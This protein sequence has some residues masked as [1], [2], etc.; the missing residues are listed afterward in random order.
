MSHSLTSLIEQ[1][2][3]A[4]HFDPTHVMSDEEIQHIIHLTTL[5]PTSFNFQNWKFIAVR[6]AEAKA[7]LSAVAFGQPKVT[8]AAVTFI[9]I[10]TLQPQ[11]HMAD[12]MKLSVDAGVIPQAQVD[13]WL[14]MAAHFYGDNAQMQ[15]DEAI[16]S[17][18]LAAMTL[19]LVAQ[20]KGLVSGPMIGFD[21]AGVTREFA[22]GANDIPVMLISVGRAAPGNWAHKVRKPQ[23]EVL[24][25]A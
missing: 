17:G 12:I 14:P 16:R 7:R 6:S 10:G 2:T 13:A 20:D 11:Q 1:R 19:M 25:F 9:V 23:S 18:A 4:N 21:P 5:S 3:S 22:L 15:R 8:D 24:Q